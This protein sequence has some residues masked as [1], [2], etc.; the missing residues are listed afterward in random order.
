MAAVTV[1]DLTYFQPA[2]SN[3]TIIEQIVSKLLLWQHINGQQS[4]LL[5]YLSQA[6]FQRKVSA[7]HISTFAMR[8]TV[9]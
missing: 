8:D 6:E 9:S 3:Y 4:S 7:L 2:S 1:T 5:G